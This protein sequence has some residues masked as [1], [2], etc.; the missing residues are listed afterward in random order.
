MQNTIILYGLNAIP[1]SL[2]TILI[3]FSKNGGTLVVIPSE[4][5]IDLASY[6]DLFKSLLPLSYGPLITLEKEISK[7]S[8]QHP[9]FQNVFEK[10]VTNFDYPKVNSFYGLTSKVLPALSYESF[11]PF[12]TSYKNCHVFSA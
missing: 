8:F 7:I 11:E 4:D 5:N 1:S 9:L 2:S 3:D 10:E 12:L 6:N